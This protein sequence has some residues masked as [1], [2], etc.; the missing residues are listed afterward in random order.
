M[1]RIALEVVGTGV[2]PQVR[3][4]AAVLAVWVLVRREGALGHPQY[5]AKHASRTGSH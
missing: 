5:R 2:A 3:V 4:E 1:K